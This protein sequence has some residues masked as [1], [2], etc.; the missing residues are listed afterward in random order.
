MTTNFM[1]KLNEAGERSNFKNVSEKFH[2]RMG[3]EKLRFII[4]N[5]I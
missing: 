4:V 3:R 5:T 2:T 1:K